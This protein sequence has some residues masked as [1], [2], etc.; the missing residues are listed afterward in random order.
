MIALSCDQI[1][2]E[3]GYFTV[4]G[5]HLIRFGKSYVCALN[6]QDYAIEKVLQ[7]SIKNKGE[8]NE[9]NIISKNISFSGT[10]SKTFEFEVEI[11]QNLKNLFLT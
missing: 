1:F 7:I 11:F 8:N 6:Y 10:G 3:E 4:T 9:D 2:G 5:S